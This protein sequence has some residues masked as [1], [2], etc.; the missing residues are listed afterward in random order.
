M[1]I[2]VSAQFHSPSVILRIMNLY[3]N[4]VFSIEVFTRQAIIMIENTF[5]ILVKYV[6]NSR[7]PTDMFL[8]DLETP[9]VSKFTD[10]VYFIQIKK[11]F[12]YVL[13]LAIATPL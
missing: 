3:S 6:V 1:F 8:H 2:Q 12:A 13:L 10:R 4:H 11:T 9:L 5:P 7:I